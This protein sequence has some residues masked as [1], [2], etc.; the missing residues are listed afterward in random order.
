MTNRTVDFR[1]SRSLKALG[2]DEPC[3]AYYDTTNPDTVQHAQ[4]PLFKNS[5][6]DVL[7]ACPTIS[8]V[9]D[10]LWFEKDIH[11]EVFVNDDRTFGC[12]V[13]KFG[14]NGDRIEDNCSGMYN[15]RTEAELAA[16]KF[17]E[18]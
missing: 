13:T 15:S 6:I 17:I 12:I 3:S 11:V 10:W 5:S 4:Q 1:T 16:I 2:F 9:L 8:Q 14:S 7:I 18:S